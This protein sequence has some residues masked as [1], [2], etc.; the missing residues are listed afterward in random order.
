MQAV[1]ESLFARPPLLQLLLV[2]LLFLLLFFTVC[3]HQSSEFEV[4]QSGAWSHMQCAYAC[5]L[6]LH[7]FTGMLVYVLQ[8]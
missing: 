2:L 7:M 4:S 3:P 5:Q 1:L 8:V 6:A